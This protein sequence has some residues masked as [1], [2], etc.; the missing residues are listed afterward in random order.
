VEIAIRISAGAPD[1]GQDLSRLRVAAERLLRKNEIAIH[2]DL[3]HAAGGL[4]Q[5]DLGIGKVLLQL[6]HQTDGSGLI[7]SDDAE[8][9]RDLHG[10]SSGGEPRKPPRIVAVPSAAAK[11]TG[12][13]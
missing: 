3:E 8:L 10:D 12:G 2:R 7:I 5:A 1:H 4:D 6:S 13:R 9:D 11:G